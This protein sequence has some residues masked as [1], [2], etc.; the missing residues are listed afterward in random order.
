MACGFPAPGFFLPPSVEL[1]LVG[2]A[3]CQRKKGWS[4][5]VVVQWR[6]HVLGGDVDSEGDSRRRYGGGQDGVRV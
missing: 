4:T 2:R 6:G 3:G 5:P 1:G